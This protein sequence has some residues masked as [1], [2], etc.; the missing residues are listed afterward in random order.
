MTWFEKG[1]LLYF[2]ILIALIIFA[3]SSGCTPFISELSDSSGCLYSTGGPAPGLPSGVVLVC[4]SGK[5]GVTATVTYE[6]REG[7]KIRIVHERPVT[8]VK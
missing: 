1:A 4:R 6:D 3:L 2:M 7:R 8:A 5:E